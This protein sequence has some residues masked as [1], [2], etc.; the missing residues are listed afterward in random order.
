[1]KYPFGYLLSDFELRSTNL[2]IQLI[3]RDVDFFLLI[4][5]SSNFESTSYIF[6]STIIQQ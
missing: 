6:E 4:R 2:L 1:M 3:I 5:L